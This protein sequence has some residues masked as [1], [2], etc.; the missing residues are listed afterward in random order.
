LCDRRTGHLQKQK[1]I[2]IAAGR[3]WLVITVRNI[4]LISF[5]IESAFNTNNNPAMA[6]TTS[7][8][9]IATRSGQEAADPRRE[10]ATPDQ[11]AGEAQ[12]I[13]RSAQAEQGDCAFI[14]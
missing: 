12:S 1:A 4:R 6:V 3:G 11:R 10:I 5:E 9:E 13:L 2:R 8:N 7:R 14:G